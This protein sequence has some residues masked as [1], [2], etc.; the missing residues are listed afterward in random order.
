M[1]INDLSS[2]KIGQVSH[3]R[4]LSH[5]LSLNTT[6]TECKQ[7]EEHSLL[8]TDVLSIQPAQT[9]SIPQFLN[10]SIILS[11]PCTLYYFSPV[12]NS[13]I[14][15]SLEKVIC[16]TTVSLFS[17]SWLPSIS[18]CFI[19]SLCFSHSPYHW[20]MALYIRAE[21]MSIMSSQWTVA[22]FLWTTNAWDKSDIFITYNLQTC[23]NETDGSISRT[24]KGNAFLTSCVNDYDFPNSLFYYSCNQH[25]LCLKCW[26]WLLWRML[27]PFKEEGFIWDLLCTS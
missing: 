22:S 20:K 24:G 13:P 25:A 3:F 2:F 26:R 5:G 14:H 12:F 8:P 4:I 21:Q 7:T 9:N 27:T 11:T 17:S 18:Y 15:P 16:R 10:I 6:T 19:M 23:V 1:R